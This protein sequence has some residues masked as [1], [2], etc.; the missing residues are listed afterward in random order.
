MA[1]I[2]GYNKANEERRAEMNLGKLRIY[3]GSSCISTDE[4]YIRLIA[5]TPSGPLMLVVCDRCGVTKKYL[6]VITTDPFTVS[7]ILQ[8]VPTVPDIPKQESRTM[9]EDAIKK[10]SVQCASD[11]RSAIDKVV[12]KKATGQ[13]ELT[14]APVA[15]KKLTRNR[16]GFCDQF[17][18][19][20]MCLLGV[21]VCREEVAIRLG[22]SVNT[23]GTWLRRNKISASKIK[24][25]RIRKSFCK[26]NKGK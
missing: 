13:G 21:G 18:K 19:E 3:D 25:D 7:M 14:L 22:I 15:K 5:T 26:A 4:E 1:F 24:A 10:A 12:S 17:R 23:L 11:I 6:A 8:P 16:R 20:I 9:I 2:T